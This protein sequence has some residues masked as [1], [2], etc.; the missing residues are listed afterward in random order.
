MHIIYILVI[1]MITIHAPRMVPISKIFQYVTSRLEI[2]IWTL[3]TGVVFVVSKLCNKAPPR[4]I[5]VLVK[6]P[7]YHV[8]QNKTI[9]VMQPNNEDSTSEKMK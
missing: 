5:R 9:N 4:G 3:D 6:T 8:K 1:Y 7:T 2:P